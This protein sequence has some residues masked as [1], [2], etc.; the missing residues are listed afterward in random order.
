MQENHVTRGVWAG[1][2]QVG[3]GAVGFFFRTGCD[4][5]LC[6]FGVQDLRELLADSSVGA[7]DDVHLSRIFQLVCLCYFHVSETATAHLAV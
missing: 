3:D 1:L 4:V 7:G 6:V 2:F 5:Y